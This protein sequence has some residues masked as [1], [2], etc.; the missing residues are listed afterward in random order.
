MTLLYGKLAPQRPAGVS[1]F[2]VYL[3]DLPPPPVAVAAPV[4][5]NWQMFL[6]D[7]YGDCTI[8]G[9][10]H[11]IVA[12]NA[13]VSE[14]D[15]VPTDPEIQQQY[16]ALTGGQDTGCVEAD[17]LHTWYRVGLFT[18][19]DGGILH[20]VE[21]DLTELLEHPKRMSKIAG[22]APVG[23]EDMVC[24]QKAIELFGHCYVGVQCPQSAQEQFAAHQPWTVVP[25]SPIEGGHRILYVGY[26][27][28]YLYAVTWGDLVAVTYDWHDAFCDEAWAVIPQAFVEKGAGPTV[29][30]TQLQADLNA[31][32]P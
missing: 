26:D 28:E 31:L 4:V 3:P 30:I 1:E 5:D 20:D 18:A 11:V 21:D 25:G 9:V 23:A 7:E 16:F 2:H 17:V 6:N 14:H 13:E 32:N 22:Y 8:A 19:N 10:G 15:A 27:H 12:A 29:D 24:I